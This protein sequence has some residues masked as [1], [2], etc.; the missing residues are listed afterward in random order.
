MEKHLQPCPAK[1]NLF[2]LSVPWTHAGAPGVGIGSLTCGVTLVLISQ[3][4]VII[5]HRMGQEG[6]LQIKDSGLTAYTPA[7]VLDSSGTD[8]PASN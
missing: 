1:T 5:L 4:M 7:L 3:Q 6:L 8:T 2:H